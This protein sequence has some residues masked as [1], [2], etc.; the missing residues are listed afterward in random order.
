MPR[1][2][3]TTGPCKPDIHYTLSP[4]VRLP[5]LE[6]LVEQQ[7]YFVIHAP[8]QTGKTT[9]MLALAKQL[10]ATEEYAAVMVSVE[11]GQPFT[12]DVGQ[13]ELA[14]LASWRRAIRVR[15]P[16]ALH[17]P[18]W[19]ISETGGRI[20][21][22]LQ[23]WAIASP[24]PLVVLIDEI[25]SLRDQALLSILRQLRDGFPDRPE[26]FPQSVGLIGLRDVRDYK[27]ASGGS[28]NLNTASPFNIKVQ[29]LILRNFSSD[30]VAE[31][32]GQHT[33]ATGQSFTA[34]AIDFAFG[35]TQ[36]QPWLVNALA[37]E[38]VEVVLPDVTKEIT[39]DHLQVAKENLIRRKDTHLDS[40]AERLREGRVRAIL[41]PMMAG[42]ELNETSSDDREFLIDLGLLRRENGSGLAIANPIYREILLRVLAQGPQDSLPSI[43]P[44]WLTASGE[45]DVSAL[46]EAFMS[47]WLQHGEPLLNSALYHEIAPH[48]VLMAF[49]HRVVNGGGTLDR[50]YAI[51]SDRMD[52]C[53]RYG[54]VTLGIELKVQRD[55]GRNQLRSGLSQIEGYLTRLGLDSG[56]LVIFDRRKAALPIAQ[57]LRS[58][59]HHTEMGKTIEVIYA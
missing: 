18:D 48:L 50:E 27:V 46:R 21:T 12:N 28:E 9:A 51:G 11:V 49:L 36:G 37:K 4:L 57:R 55:D 59:L 26:A 22:A 15:L 40:L 53:L 19:S 10:T 56:W 1:H 14:I 5:N 3:N 54:Q 45:L 42:Q 34:A 24:L 23:E 52:L 35:L 47:F 13:T 8:R 7:N 32:Y 6:Q 58:Q 16:A 38:V 30:E 20:Q 17:P 43:T 33:Q 29:S 44:T 41:E 2:F 31:L 25:D 39:I